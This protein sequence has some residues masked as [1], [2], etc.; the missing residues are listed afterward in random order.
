M[1]W[2]S[3][4]ARWVSYSSFLL[5]ALLTLAG[6]STVLPPPSFS[7]N[8]SGTW[9]S[10]AAPPQGGTFQAKVTQT[11]QNLAGTVT[12]TGSPLISSGTV[13]GTVQG[14]QISFGIL[15]GGITAITFTGS[16]SGNTAS[17]TYAA[18]NGDVG[19]W[20]ATRQ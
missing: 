16:F 7:G 13:S 9:S 15:T 18:A 11:G 20:Q 19:T 4:H 2:L 12:V 17:G 5:V 1:H 14:N 8:W 6:C 3:G 10:T